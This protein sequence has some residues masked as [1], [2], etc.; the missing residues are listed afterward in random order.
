MRIA[1]GSDHGGYE[2]KAL[3]L[4]LLREQ[5]HE[6]EDFGC[7]SP[8]SVDYA[9][10]A[11]PVAEAVAAGR[12]ERGILIC[13]TGVGVSISANKVRGVRCALCGDPVTAQLTRAHNDSNVLAMGQRIIGEEA[14]KA[15]VRVWLETP[16]EGGRHA[17]RI[18]KIA[19]YE[20]NPA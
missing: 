9:D 13:G 7:D 11:L 12:F 4:P 1:I 17:R 14:M 19:A 15:I 5:G 3:L 2:Y 10:Y 6:V 18:E 8:A 16:F 20:T